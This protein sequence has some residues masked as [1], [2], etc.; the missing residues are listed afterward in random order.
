M[1]VFTGLILLLFLGAI[2][3]FAIQNQRPVEMR[4]LN[5]GISFPLAGVAVASYVLGMLSGWSVLRFFRRSVRRV[6]EPTHHRHQ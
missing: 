6:Q 2:L 4:F 3:L 5:W 1:R